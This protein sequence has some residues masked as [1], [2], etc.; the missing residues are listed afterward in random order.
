MDKD[1]KTRENRARRAARRQGL[2]LRKSRTRDLRAVGYGTY[3]LTD[4]KTGQT[5]RWGT[6]DGLALNITEI[7]EVLDGTTPVRKHHH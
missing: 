7:E 2:T 5:I 4:T 1:A 3:W 6:R